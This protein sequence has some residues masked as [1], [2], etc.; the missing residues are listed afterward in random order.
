MYLVHNQYNAARVI[1]VKSHDNYSHVTCHMSH[2]NFISFKQLWISMMFISCFLWYLCDLWNQLLF[3]RP[4]RHVFCDYNAFRY[5]RHCLVCRQI[6]CK[7]ICNLSAQNASQYV[8]ILLLFT[9]VFHICVAVF[10]WWVICG[11]CSWLS[12]R[13]MVITNSE[14]WNSFC[15]GLWSSAHLASV[16]LCRSYLQ[17]SATLTTSLLTWMSHGEH[18][19]LL[20]VIA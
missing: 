1:M 13:K 9:F 5:Y 18:T 4:R 7:S 14:G 2:D 12:L 6:H 8:L 17:I 3:H 16:G 20:P 10:L 15:W 19:Y 11:L